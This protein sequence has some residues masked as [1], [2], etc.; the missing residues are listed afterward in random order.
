MCYFHFILFKKIHLKHCNAL[1]EFFFFRLL[2]MKSFSTNMKMTD[3]KEAASGI[4]DYF[5]SENKSLFHCESTRLSLYSF[6]LFICCSVFCG[7]KRMNVT[8]SMRWSI[9]VSNE[10]SQRSKKEMPLA[11]CL[12]ILSWGWG[13]GAQLMKYR[14]RF[15]TIGKVSVEFHRDLSNLC[16]SCNCANSWGDGGV[17]VNGW[18]TGAGTK[19]RKYFETSSPPATF[20]YMA[21]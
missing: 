19:L 3:M 17:D 8:H 12:E 5:S 1:I 16:H 11:A 4:F 9:W 2:T 15:K 10:S 13:G 14:Y 20:F 7:R 18:Q 6:L 21:P